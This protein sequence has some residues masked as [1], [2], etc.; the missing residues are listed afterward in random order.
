M[1]NFILYEDAKMMRERYKKIIIK[2][3]GKNKN[4]TIHE[5]DKYDDD[6][7]TAMDN[8]IG[9]RIYLLDLEVPGKTGIDFA[10][11]I[12]N[13]GDWNS[14]IIMIT[15]HEEFG[16]IAFTGRLLMLDF[17]SKMSDIEKE[18]KEALSLAINITGSN[19]GLKCF[20]HGV[21]YHIPYNDILF[22]EKMVNDN[23]CNIVTKGKKYLIR[24]TISHLQEELDKNRFM[25]T[26]RGCIVNLDN[27]TSVDFVNNIISFGD[28]IKID[29]IARD[30][31]KE[32]KE[33]LEI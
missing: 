28:N 27:I 7:Q 25:K 33:R 11:E 10:R 6:T 3:M 21:L 22:I 1:I 12:R 26:H 29:L 14:Q 16:T 24:D 8:I 23:N 13:A 31:K 17:I 20:S 30:K 4:Y 5:F 18:L 15:S 19:D 9:E 2:L 32:L